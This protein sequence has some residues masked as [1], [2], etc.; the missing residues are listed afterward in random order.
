MQS[1]KLDAL[2]FT[3]TLLYPSS[4]IRSK[5]NQLLPLA[6]AA[7]NDDWYKIIAEGLRVLSSIIVVSKSTTGCI[8]FSTSAFS[9]SANAMEI[10]EKPR[11]ELQETDLRDI[12]IS[13]YQ[14]VVPRL[15]LSDID[16]EIKENAIL[17]IGKLFK[18]LGIYLCS[19]YDYLPSTLDILQKRLENEVTRNATLKALIDIASSDLFVHTPVDTSKHFNEIVKV[20]AL[21]LRQQSRSLKLN[22]LQT[23]DSLFASVC[24]HQVR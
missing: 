14:S 5:I 11:T 18:H 10:D 8:D 4:I 3:R 20:L 17:T 7:T 19:D 1:L 21:F 16:Q 6:I 2:V 9:A 13:I 15:K 23:I 24:S 12:S 22:T